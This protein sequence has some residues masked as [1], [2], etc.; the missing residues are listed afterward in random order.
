M[1]HYESALSEIVEQL[2]GTD[3]TLAS[4]LADILAAA[5][6][7]LIEAQLTGAIGT[8]PGERARLITA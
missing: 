7:E 6:Q 5:I 2:T 1:A 8:E 3:A 4:S